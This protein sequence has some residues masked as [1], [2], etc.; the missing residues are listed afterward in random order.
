MVAASSQI[1][2]LEEQLRTAAADAAAGQA[3]AQA[4]D[5]AREVESAR[6][7]EARASRLAADA[8]KAK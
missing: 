5:A 8:K 6:V 3:D 7:R 2:E 4:A 1:A